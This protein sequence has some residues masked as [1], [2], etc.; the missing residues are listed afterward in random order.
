MFRVHGMF[1]TASE[2]SGM[3]YYGRGEASQPPDLEPL[4]IVSIEQSFFEKVM[5]I[6]RSPDLCMTKELTIIARIL[7]FANI[8]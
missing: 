4:E 3:R 1:S 8:G 5:R 6:V 7:L 2:D